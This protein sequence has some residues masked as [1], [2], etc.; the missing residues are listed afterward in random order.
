MNTQERRKRISAELEILPDN[1]IKEIDEFIDQLK[2]QEKPS[3]LE[4]S[5]LAFASESALA[6]DWN[7]PEEDKAWQGL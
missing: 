3:T 7:L 5:Q 6:K 2:S 1:M 4:S